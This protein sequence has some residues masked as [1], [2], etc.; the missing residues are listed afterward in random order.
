MN[1][2]SLIN[3][4][5]ST[6][7]IKLVRIEPEPRVQFSNPHS[8]DSE[9]VGSVSPEVNKVLNLL[10]YTTTNSTEYNAEKFPSGYH[11]L[12]IDGHEFQGQRDPHQRLVGVPFNFEGATVLDLGCN[13]GGMLHSIADL[14]QVGVGVDYDHKMIN[15]ANRIRTHNKVS[16]L[17]FY[18]FDLEQE[19]LDLLRNFVPGVRID[20]I[21][22]LSVCMWIR[23]WTTVIDKARLMS[24]CLLFESNGSDEQQHEQ[25]EYL[26]SCYSD[27]LL[28]RG[29]SLDD[30]GQRRRRLFLCRGTA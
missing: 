22:L 27:V 15:A 7:G 14:I 1:F 19:N 5:L 24:N 18:V 26:R 16:N 21:F 25:E 6:L 11:K 4:S 29:E 20:I 12:R 17:S 9:T 2:S 8:V 13:Q 23:N 30:P 10:S 3:R 28:V